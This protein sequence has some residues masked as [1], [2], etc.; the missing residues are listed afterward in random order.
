MTLQ[1]VHA[2]NARKTVDNVHLH[3]VDNVHVHVH[4]NVHVRVQK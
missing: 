2:D 1:D 4:G 3:V